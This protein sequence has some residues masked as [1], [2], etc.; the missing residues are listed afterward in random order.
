MPD[1]TVTT[2]WKGLTDKVEPVAESVV[3]S[4]AAHPRTALRHTSPADSL[5]AET[6]PAGC[7]TTDAAGRRLRRLRWT[8]I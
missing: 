7:R 1:D 3:G 8:G 4:V 5:S 6:A 2:S